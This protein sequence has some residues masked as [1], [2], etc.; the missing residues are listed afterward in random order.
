MGRIL[1][2]LEEERTGTQQTFRCL[3]CGHALGAADDWHRLAGVYDESINHHEPSNVNTRDDTFVLRHYC[4][5]SCG[6]LFEVE[7]VARV[8]E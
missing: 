2:Y 6:V 7:M 5:R 8:A 4:C 1:E 3:K